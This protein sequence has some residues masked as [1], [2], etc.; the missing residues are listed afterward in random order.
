MIPSTPNIC[1][2]SAS[3]DA[4]GVSH[5]GHHCERIRAALTDANGTDCVR[6]VLYGTVVC[7]P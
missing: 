7:H 1:Q 4:L 5:G 6:H 3:T 2:E